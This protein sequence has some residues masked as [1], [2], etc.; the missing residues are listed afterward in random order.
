MLE[1]LPDP[2]DLS[3]PRVALARFCYADSYRSFC[4]APFSWGAW[5]YATDGH[6]LARVPRLDGVLE[7]L[8]APRADWLDAFFGSRPWALTPLRLA[9]GGPPGVVTCSDCEGSGIDCFYAGASITKKCD[10]CDGKGT[11]RAK[12]YWRLRGAWFADEVLRTVDGL[13]GLHA[14]A[15]FTPDYTAPHNA[16]LFAWDG[17]KVCLAMVLGHG[18]TGGDAE[19]VTP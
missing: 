10:E 17:G 19:E 15:A 1:V 11:Q 8:D 3:D 16:P 12:R 5:S 2:V 18:L 13:P 14:E 7:N 6:K 9:L 4:R